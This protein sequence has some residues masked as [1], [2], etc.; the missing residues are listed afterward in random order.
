[1][2]MFDVVENVLK[3]TSIS[4]PRRCSCLLQWCPPATS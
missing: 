1:M 4:T 3:K 2:I